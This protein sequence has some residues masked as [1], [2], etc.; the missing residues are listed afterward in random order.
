MTNLKPVFVSYRHAWRGEVEELANSLRLRGLRVLLDS[1]DPGEFSGSSMYDEMRRVIEQD[2]SAMLLHVTQDILDSPAIWK[3]EVSTALRRRTAGKD[4][5]ILPFF[6]NLSPDKLREAAPE[7][8]LLAACNGIPAIPPAGADVD[9]FL[10][11]KRAA[12]AGILLHRIL[13]GGS[14]PITL[15]IWTRKT[16]A[17]NRASDLLLDWSSVYPDDAVGT[18]AARADAQAALNQ[19]AALLANASIHDLHLQAKTHLSAAVLFGSIFT[20]RTGFRLHIEQEGE[21]GIATWHSEGPV[22]DSTPQVH[23]IQTD[24]ARDEICLIV[25]T[26]RPETVTSVEKSLQRLGITYGGRIIVRPA[27]GESRSSIPSDACARR[28]A[29][30]VASQ[31]MRARTEWGARRT[32]LFISSPVA[33]AVLIGRELNGLGPIHVYEH[34]RGTDFYSQAF[35]IA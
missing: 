8:T 19:L 27:S 14:R 35:T 4:F 31:L 9:S 26:S 29:K 33:L 28:L 11:E 7:G 10:A 5:L 6:R 32:H 2:C 12:A 22:D 30:T 25:S 17:V 34:H 3:V 13:K 15:S 1:S 23:S 18:P 20:S 21:H 16:A 24:P